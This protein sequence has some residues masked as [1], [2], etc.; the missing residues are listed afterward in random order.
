MFFNR[1]V[2]NYCCFQQGQSPAKALY[3]QVSFE[4]EFK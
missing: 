2:M 4:Y 3:A 1:I